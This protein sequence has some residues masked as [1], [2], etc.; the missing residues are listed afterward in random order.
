VTFN[1]QEYADT[2]LDFWGDNSPLYLMSRFEHVGHYIMGT[3]NFVCDVMSLINHNGFD[4]INDFEKIMN[5]SQKCYE[6]LNK[7]GYQEWVMEN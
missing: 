1:L 5:T 6:Y 7:Y 3:K 2:V 4:F